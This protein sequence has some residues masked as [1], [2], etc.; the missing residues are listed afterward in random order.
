MDIIKIFAAAILM[1]FVASAITLAQMPPQMQQHQQKQEKID[2]SDGDMKKFAAAFQEVQTINQSTQVKMQKAIQDEGLKIERFQEIQ[3]I[4][5]NPKQDGDISDN[6]LKKFK[7]AAG[8]LGQIQMQAQ[9]SMQKKI[10]GEG[11][12]IQRYQKIMASLQQDPE[13]Q[14]KLKE[15]LAG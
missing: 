7:S 2:I 14:K 5:N 6:E 11:L 10:K 13:L 12:T 9:Q 1:V 8:K 3:Q 15:M 4:Q